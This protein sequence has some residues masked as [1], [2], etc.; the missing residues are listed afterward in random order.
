MAFYGTP[1][2]F[3][4]WSNYPVYVMVHRLRLAAGPT[5]MNFHDPN[6]DLLLSP[7]QSVCSRRPPSS[8]TTTSPTYISDNDFHGVNDGADLIDRWHRD[9]AYRVLADHSRA[10]AHA[11]ADGLLPGRQGLALK[12]RH[13]IHRSARAAMLTELDQDSVGPSLLARLVA[14]VS[15]IE[16]LSSP[17]AYHATASG[18]SARQPGRI[19]QQQVSRADISVVTVS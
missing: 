12:L 2:C 1:R 6:F 17:C 10:L 18:P 4:L 3:N 7:P 8:S 13:L 15:R 16:S 11:L 5:L 14:Q 9:V 19:S